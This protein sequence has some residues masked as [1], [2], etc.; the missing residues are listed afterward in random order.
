MWA[1]ALEA[2][3]PRRGRSVALLLALAGLLRPEAWILASGYVA[4]LWWADRRIDPVVAALG[5][6]APL[7]WFLLDARVTGDPLFSLHQTSFVVDSIGEDVPV[8]RVPDRLVSFLG[9]TVRP[10]V[11]L[12]GVVGPRARLARPPPPR[13]TRARRPAA[14]LAG[15]IVAFVGSAIAVGTVQQRYLTLPA[16]ASACSRRTPCSASA[17]G[18]ARS[19]RAGARARSSSPSSA[20]SAAPCSCPGSCAA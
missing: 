10:P 16:V 20:C 8:W 1:G 7:L 18:R 2:E 5:V 4:W 3:R 11:L 19:R 15:G 6:G 17:T 9:S 14:L 12:L 13:A